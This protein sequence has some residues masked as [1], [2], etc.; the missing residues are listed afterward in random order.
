M[1]AADLYSSFN[2]ADES[3]V[4]NVG[5]KF[6]DTILSLSGGVSTKELFRTFMGR[7]PSPDA[8]LELTG[9]KKSD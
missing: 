2:A 8:L 5:L 1:L 9:I 3:E 6:R 7:D 4:G